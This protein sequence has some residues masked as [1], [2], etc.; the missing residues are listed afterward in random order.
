MK[1]RSA[2]CIIMI[3]YNHKTQVLSRHNIS[4]WM[5][6]HCPIDDLNNLNCVSQ[7]WKEHCLIVAHLQFTCISSVLPPFL[8]ILQNRQQRNVWM[9]LE[10]IE[11]TF[12][13]FFWT[14]KFAL[15]ERHSYWTCCRS[16]SSMKSWFHC[17][18]L[19]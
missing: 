5:W 18:F 19:K 11:T 16:F 13:H 9:Q 8:G 17:L 6:S 7:Y 12:S 1:K 2:Q 10:W 14:V 15:L 4:A 3:Q